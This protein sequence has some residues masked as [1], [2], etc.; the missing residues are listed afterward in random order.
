MHPKCFQL[1]HLLNFVLATLCDL[2]ALTQQDTSWSEQ[3]TAK[4]EFAAMPAIRRNMTANPITRV[5]RFMTFPP[6]P[7]SPA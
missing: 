2:S 6:F 5:V 7:V 1:Q 4:V 3:L